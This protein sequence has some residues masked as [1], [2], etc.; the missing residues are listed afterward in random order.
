MVFGGLD[1]G[2]S[3]VKCAL[4]NEKGG[5]VVLAR[6]EYDCMAEN[7]RYELDGNLVWEKTKEALREA[8]ARTTEPIEA[9]AVSAIGEAGVGL[10]E[11]DRVVAPS[12]L[13]NDIRGM[14]ESR[15]LCKKLGRQKIYEKT[16]NVPNGTYTIEKLMWIRERE[17]YYKNIKKIFLYED[18][19][20]YMLTGMRGISYSL[21]AR[22]MAFDITKK[23]WDDT[24]FEAAGVKKELM[25]EAFPSG[26][27][28]GTIR[29]ELAEELGI[30][31]NAKILTGGHDG[32]CCALG[33]GMTD[34]KIAVN[35]S[36]SCETI[37]VLMDGPCRE[38]FMM[39]SNYS[40]I[41]YIMEDTYATYGLC[42]TSG[43]IIKW[44]RNRL[45]GGC[46]YKE[47]DQSVSD[48]PS[49]IIVIPD[50][51]VSGTP[52]FSL[53]AKGMLYGITLDTS[54]SDLFRAMLEGTAFHMRMN[55]EIMEKNGIV[56]PD[57]R[58]VGGA[59]FSPVWMQI[60]ADIWE[61]AVATVEGNE[62]GVMGCAML[63]GKEAGAFDTLEQGAEKLIRLG[64]TYMPDKKYREYYRE[65]YEQFKEM[66]EWKNRRMKNAGK[67]ERI[68][69]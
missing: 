66:F 7:G 69:E 36:G 17:E 14:E 19:I 27:V 65:L 33:A 35:V 4:F 68:A 40:C 54:L 42:L 16:G 37:S 67:Y 13:F 41:P 25:S 18:F 20:I 15:R 57:I 8:A 48:K 12:L 29:S 30:S 64:R 9:L 59:A 56:I 51:S 52:C 2:S 39:E 38:T 43:S 28:V 32:W 61:R 53:D 62:A 60:K 5:R 21:A 45:G 31:G 34:Q 1:I 63:A 26:T 3:G 50:F 10:D 6:R 24:V 58:T 23:K 55:M 46:S 49:G 47:L 44:F 22:T 11:H